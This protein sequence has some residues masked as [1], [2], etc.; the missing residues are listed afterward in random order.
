MEILGVGPSELVFIILIAILVLGP[1]EMQRAGK[2]L[3]RLLN[4]INRSELW[5]LLTS[6]TRE[7]SDM[8]RKWMR[9][10]NLEQWEAEQG[11]KNLIDPRTRMPVSA[12]SKAAEP[13]PAAA[14]SPS[15]PAEEPPTEE[16]E[17]ISTDQND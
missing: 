12:L 16:G 1:K 2:T 14:T 17:N 9:E 7:I 15:V 5:K 11:T 4:Q 3:G 8:P 6:T 10:A 13:A